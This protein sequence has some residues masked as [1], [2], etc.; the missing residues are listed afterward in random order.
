M[1]TSATA[2]FPGDI[3]KSE[4]DKCSYRHIRLPNGLQA[5]LVHE[6]NCHKAA[7]AL[8]VHVGSFH[9]PENIPG[10]A[11]FLEHLLFMGTEK[12]P[13]ENDYGKVY[14]CNYDMYSILLVFE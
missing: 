5:L 10:L 9:D 13:D 7:A 4:T 11:H 2:V 14:L 1:S 6:P 8:D 12:Y 3:Q